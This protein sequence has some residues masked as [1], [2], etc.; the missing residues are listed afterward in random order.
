MLSIFQTETTA[1]E[2]QVAALQTQLAAAQGRISLL[3]E[4]ELLAGGSLESLKTAIDKV[5]ALAPDAIANLRAAVLNLFSGSDNSSDGGNGNQ[6]SPTPQPSPSPEAELEPLTGQLCELTSPWYHPPAD[7]AHVESDTACTVDTPEPQPEQLLSA[8]NCSQFSNPLLTS[9][10]PETEPEQLPYVELIPVSHCVAY[11]RRSTDGEIICCYLAGNN[12]N[13]LKDWGSWLCNQ[14]SVGSGFE[15]REAKRMTAYKWELK[16]WGMSL[17]QI[18]RLAE[19][20]TTKTPPSRYHVASF[21]VAANLLQTDED[22][23]PQFVEAVAESSEVKP[24]PRMFQVGDR[25]EVISDRHGVELVGQTGTVTAG[26]AAGAAVDVG[27]TLRWFCSDEL[28][29]SET[30]EFPVDDSR[31][32][33]E[34]IAL[35][36][37]QPPVPASTLAYNPYPMGRRGAAANF[38]AY[39]A[40]KAIEREQKALAAST[41][42]DEPDF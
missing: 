9:D 25:V 7:A 28:A 15:L 34:K 32:E 35:D 21:P 11:Q 23:T 18:Q 33:I 20:D 26:T 38:E 29:I 36:S 14:H 41:A 40:A 12:K 5:T 10:V 17:K 22:S 39:Q 30:P 3:N 19:T 2:S 31:G 16:I 8:N 24:D 42:D 37:I 27:G 6:P 1:L 13:R 4:T